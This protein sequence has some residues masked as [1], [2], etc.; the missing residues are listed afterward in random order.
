MWIWM[1]ALQTLSLAHMLEPIFLAENLLE[2]WAF[3]QIMIK[4]NRLLLFFQYVS[5]LTIPQSG[6]LMGQEGEFFVL[7][8]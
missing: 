3:V 8:S 5:P 4:Q 6:K 7:Y 1:K 2:Y